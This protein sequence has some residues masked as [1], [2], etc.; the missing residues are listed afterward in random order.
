MHRGHHG[1]TN[2]G[3]YIAAMIIKQ[4]GRSRIHFK[5]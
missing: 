3:K 5:A 1:K 2:C 4:I